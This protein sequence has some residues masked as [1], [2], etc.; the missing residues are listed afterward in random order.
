MRRAV[1]CAF[2][3]SMVLAGGMIPFSPDAAADAQAVFGFGAGDYSA[4]LRSSRIL[5]GSTT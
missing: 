4:L 3:A 5:D 2:A 1:L